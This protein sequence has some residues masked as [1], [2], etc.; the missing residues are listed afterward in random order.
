M[1][2]PVTKITYILTFAPPYLE[3]FLRSIWGAIFQSTVLILPQIKLNSQLSCCAFFFKSEG[4][5]GQA[6]KQKNNSKVTLSPE[7]H[8]NTC[9]L[10]TGSCPGPPISRFLFL[11]LWIIS[12]DQFSSSP[13]FSGGELFTNSGFLPRFYPLTFFPPWAV[14]FLTLFPSL[15]GSYFIC[16]FP[17]FVSYL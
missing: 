2:C 9:T 8:K 12:Q 16:S 4:S 7:L 6:L 10:C 17:G 13:F 14:V 3:Q 15:G 11:V 5:N 1:Y